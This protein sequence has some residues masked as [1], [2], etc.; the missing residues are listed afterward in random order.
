MNLLKET[1]NG[2]KKEVEE[3]FASIM[4]QLKTV[5]TDLNE[6][7][8]LIEINHQFKKEFDITKEDYST[9]LKTIRN[10]AS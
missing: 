1:C 10:K 6:E 4:T 7:S 2:I 9:R 5:M 8:E 3:K